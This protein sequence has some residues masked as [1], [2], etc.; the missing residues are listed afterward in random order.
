MTRESVRSDL[1]RLGVL[2]AQGMREARA[3]E[4]PTVRLDAEGWL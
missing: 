4:R 2:V 1:I 3:N